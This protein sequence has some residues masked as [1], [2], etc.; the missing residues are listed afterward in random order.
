MP[1]QA[2]S[3]HYPELPET[4]GVRVR[5]T[6]TAEP[7]TY[8]DGRILGRTIMAKDLDTK[9]H[10]ADV[11]VWVGK[12]GLEAVVDELKDQVHDRDVVKV[13][14]LRAA[15]GNKDTEELAEELAEMASV[16]IVDVR[17]NTAVYH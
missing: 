17:G 1:V 15:R 13:K 11:T 10:E 5:H 3:L 4:G 9:A 8:I 16:D 6:Q 7:L 2:R 14:F 12:S